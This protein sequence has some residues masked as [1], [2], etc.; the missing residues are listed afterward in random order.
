MRVPI[1]IDRTIYNIL[2]GR[3]ALLSSSRVLAVL[4]REGN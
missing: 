2:K 4:Y 3:T 1:N